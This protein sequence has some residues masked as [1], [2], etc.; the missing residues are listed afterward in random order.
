[1]SCFG[2]F[3]SGIFSAHLVVHASESFTLAGHVFIAMH[4]SEFSAS[5]ATTKVWPSILCN[6]RKLQEERVRTHEPTSSLSHNLNLR[7]RIIPVLYRTRKLFA[8]PNPQR[9]IHLYG[10]R[11]IEKLEKPATF[12]RQNKSIGRVLFEGVP[13]VL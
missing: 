1:M 3:G 10:V 12:D 6:I 13:N 11:K 4:A 9:H 2:L 5:S 8:V 7:T